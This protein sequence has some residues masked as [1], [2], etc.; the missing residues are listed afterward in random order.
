M[1][2]WL[3]T[4][5][6]EEDLVLCGFH[7]IDEEFQVERLFYYKKSED[8]AVVY[9]LDVDRNARDIL[10]KLRLFH[11]RRRRV[12]PVSGDIRSGGEPVTRARAT[13]LATHIIWLF[14]LLTLPACF[15]QG[16]PCGAETSDPFAQHDLSF[17]GR[18]ELDEECAC[19]CGDGERFA[20]PRD[21]ECVAIQAPCVDPEG[22]EGRLECE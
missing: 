2:A 15:Q 16:C 6:D 11:A 8:R 9:S 18:H 21:T 14:V 5:E 4:A 1:E 3:E 12:G 13:S 22:R 19:R 10:D 7:P 20:L 17:S